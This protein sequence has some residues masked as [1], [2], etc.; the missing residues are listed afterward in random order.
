[1]PYL[2]PSLGVVRKNTGKCRWRFCVRILNV[3]HELL[4]V[5]DSVVICEIWIS[6]YLYRC[7]LTLGRR[8]EAWTK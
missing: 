2:Y 6:Y 8:S 5:A 3:P 4:S 7:F 1:M